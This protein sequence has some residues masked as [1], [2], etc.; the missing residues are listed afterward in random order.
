MASV[1]ARSRIAGRRRWSWLVGLC[2]ALAASP[3][4]AQVSL[5][6]PDAQ[7]RL[8]GY[9]TPEECLVAVARVRDS[10]TAASRVW[11]DTVPSTPEEAAAPLPAAVVQAAERCGAR[12]LAAIDTAPRAGFGALFQLA[13]L[14]GRDADAR[15]IAAGWLQAVGS[16]PGPGRA[17]ALDS[18][19]SSYLGATYDRKGALRAQPARFE[20]A[21]PHL[22]ELLKM[23]AAEAL[24]RTRLSAYVH[25]FQAAQSADDSVR[26]DR[27]AQ[28]LKAITASLT[29]AER[30]RDNFDQAAK[31]AF[32]ALRVLERR[33]LLDSLRYGTAGY[34]SLL[35]RQWAIA[36]GE[37]P[38]AMKLPVGQ[39]APAVEGR[40]WFG[41]DSGTTRPAKGKVSL[42]VFLN[43][44]ETR[45]STQLEVGCAGLA[46]CSVA[47]GMLRRLAQRYPELQ[48]TL[49]SRT[50]GYLGELEPPTP[51][52][53]AD[54]L[55][56]SW[57]GRQR[58][59]AALVVAETDFWRLPGLDRRRIDRDRPN[60]TRYTFGRRWQV[61]SGSAYVIDPEGTIVDVGSMINRTEERRLD[62]LLA[63]LFAQRT[64][65]R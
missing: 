63:A 36:S 59:P 49:V 24:W 25:F 9:R 57:L 1:F 51:A 52:A 26:L 41:A 40:F 16:K 65:S 10:V 64:A 47:Y 13:L 5:S 3:A 44:H 42:I 39:P 38:D 15:R 31:W 50:F 46:K 7:V 29:A 22:D 53:E 32:A 30:R 55:R 33:P 2:A 34:V 8:E 18:I 60:E 4:A 45:Y 27:A 54:S 48:I 23:S 12:L 21:E 43:S 58:I 35:K 14:A 56:S 19:A 6:W 62:A 28:G 37:T 61:T 11:R 17:A 20:L